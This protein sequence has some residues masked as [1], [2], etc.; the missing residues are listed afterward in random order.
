MEKKMFDFIE[1]T[2]QRNGECLIPVMPKLDTRDI[3]WKDGRAINWK[4]SG[5]SKWGEDITK[6]FL[7]GMV[8]NHK[9]LVITQEKWEIFKKTGRSRAYF[10]DTLVVF[11]NILFCFAFYYLIYC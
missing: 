8:P 3:V 2:I 10:G 11:C 7:R 4:E 5:K 6:E 9:H 1:K